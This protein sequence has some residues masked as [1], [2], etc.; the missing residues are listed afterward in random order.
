MALRK[1]Y[2]LVSAVTSFVAVDERKDAAVDG[3][4]EVRRVPVQLTAGWGGAGRLLSRSRMGGFGG[5]ALGFVSC[6]CAPTFVNGANMVR[7]HVLQSFAKADFQGF[8]ALP[9]E[10]ARPARAATD[11]VFELLLTQRSDGAFLL[12]EVLRTWLGPRL[13]RIEA[14]IALH[15][16]ALGVTALVLAL[17]TAEAADRRD[18]WLPAATKARRWLS[19][20]GASFDPAGIL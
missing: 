7:E 8:D 9:A 15:G 13:P 4:A 3:P 11:R 17:L 18:E 1:R 6:C 20:Q 10:P 19:R 16:E 5:G 14:A 2:C 12:S